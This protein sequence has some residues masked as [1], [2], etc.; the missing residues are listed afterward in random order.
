M[1]SLLITTPACLLRHDVAA[2]RT[3]LLENTRPA[4]FGLSWFGGAE[5]PFLSHSNLRPGDLTSVEHYLASEVGS[6]SDGQSEHPLQLSA[7]HQI[8]CLEHPYLAA[9]NTGRNEVRIVNTIDWFSKRL[10][11]D[12]VVWDRYDPSGNPGSHFNSLFFAESTLYVLAH[13]FEKGSYSVAIQ[14]PEGYPLER[15]HYNAINLHNLWP[16]DRRCILSCASIAGGLIELTTMKTLWRS[17]RGDCYTRGLA[18]F[19]GDIFIGSSQRKGAN[20]FDDVGSLSGIWVIDGETFSTKGF[21]TLG[22]FGVVLDLRIAD[23]FDPSHPVGPLICGPEL[24]GIPVEAFLEE[25]RLIGPVSPTRHQAIV[26]R[27]PGKVTASAPP[28]IGGQVP[29]ALR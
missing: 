24:S 27:Q 3:F 7:P 28:N 14:W 10:Y 8:L 15:T 21:I 25:P 5:R 18:S 11:F 20:L 22:N 4:Y 6:I 12:D 17:P 13:N 19:D 16:R 1:A 2:G 9:T 23:A 26:C 29:I